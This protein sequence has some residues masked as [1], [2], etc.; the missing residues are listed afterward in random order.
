MFLY[1]IFGHP[2]YWMDN[3]LTK[4]RPKEQEQEWCIRM[5]LTIDALGYWDS[6]CSFI[7]YLK[8]NEFSFNKAQIDTY[9][10]I[11]AQDCE[12]DKYDLLDETDLETSLEKV[13]QEYINIANKCFKIQEQDAVDLLKKQ[14]K[15]YKFAKQALGEDI[16]KWSA[17]FDDSKGIWSQ[18]FRPELERIAIEYNKRAEEKTNTITSDLL[19]E[20]R[21]IY[22]SVTKFIIRYN[23]ATSVLTLPV[24]ASVKGSPGGAARISM[25]ATEME[26]ANRKDNIRKVLLKP[27]D[28]EIKYALQAGNRGYGGFD[29]V[30]K[31]MEKAYA[32]AWDRLRLAYINYNRFQ[33]GEII[34][35]TSIEMQTEFQSEQNNGN[36]GSVSSES[37]NSGGFGSFSSILTEDFRKNSD[38]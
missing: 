3:E 9:F 32:L 27:I 4:R 14:T 22:D 35:T 37:R 25:M 6:N 1:N 11:A 16:E 5:F 21:K 34:F 12:T 2:I 28:D 38:D 10:N 7:D 13:E 33:D 29:K 18:K 26:L 24:K 15:E 31:E 36:L 8:V 17:S 20:T 30:I 23:H 19:R